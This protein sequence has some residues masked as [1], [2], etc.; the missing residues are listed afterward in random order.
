ML[1]GEH[2]ACR[3][4]PS[5]CGSGLG[6]SPHTHQVLPL[7]PQHLGDSGP[8]LKSLF[9]S[10]CFLKGGCA[11]GCI[12]MAT[13]CG[14]DMGF[15]HGHP[16]YAWMQSKGQ[17]GLDTAWPR[18]G[19]WAFVL[20]PTPSL[21]QVLPGLSASYPRH[22][23]PLHFPAEVG[24]VRVHLPGAAEHGGIRIGCLEFYPITLQLPCGCLG[25]S[26]GR[27]AFL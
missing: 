1:S 6:P 27:A 14:Q 15:G 21:R 19:A 24:T 9:V 22:K 16:S 11:P 25:S 13:V 23:E 17:C 12:M 3:H 5:H 26:R 10:S 2:P 20:G 18:P 4:V 8:A 7:C